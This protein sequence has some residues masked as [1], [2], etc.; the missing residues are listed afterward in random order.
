MMIGLVG[1]PSSGKSSFFKAATMT[2]VKIS[3]VPFTTIQPNL[4]LAYVII[5]CVD[6]NFGLKCNPRS[7]S[8]LDGKRFVPVKLIDVAGLVPGAHDGRGLGNKFLDDLRQADALIHVVDASG[9]TDEEGNPTTG[10][11]PMRDV[12][13][14]EREID[15]WIHSILE[16]A[17]PKISKLK[18]DSEILQVLSDQLSGLGISRIEIEETLQKIE[19]PLSIEFATALRAKSKPI[20]VAANKCDIDSAKENSRKLAEAIGAIPTSAEAEIVLKKA[21]EKGMIK[22]LPGSDFE[23]I[24]GLDEKQRHALDII[25]QKVITPYSSTGIQKCLD[26]AIFQTLGCIAVY[27]VTN[28]NKMSD[29]EGRVL[30]DVHLV[31]KG[32]TVRELA[33]RIHTS[34]GEKFIAGIDARTKKKLSADYVLQDKDVVEIMFSK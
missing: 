19:N 29:K 2:D 4:G 8:C 20:I 16:K 3:P 6:R 24:G 22:Y 11:E 17:A 26:K 14:L 13:F 23:I 1:K 21:A 27:P 25:R 31:P 33:F 5:D 15:W 32:T 9:Q 30:P 7:G 18:S 10:H 12:E 28:S 34:I